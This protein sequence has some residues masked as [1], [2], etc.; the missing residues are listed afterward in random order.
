MELDANDKKLLQRA[1]AKIRTA[2]EIMT[3]LADYFR[4]KYELTTEN[5]I[6]PDGQIIR[7]PAL[8]GTKAISLNTRE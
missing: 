3:F 5:Q 2:N 1:H 4:D 7:I 6:T 8:D